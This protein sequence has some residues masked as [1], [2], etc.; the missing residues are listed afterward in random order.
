[1][2]DIEALCRS[3]LA[4]LAGAT[5]KDPAIRAAIEEACEGTRGA[6]AGGVGAIKGT[7]TPASQRYLAPSLAAGAAGPAAALAAAIGR[8][9]GS[10]HWYYGYKPVEGQPDLPNR[11]A[12]CEFVG[13]TSPVHSDTMRLGLTLI[14]PGTHYPVHAHPAVE[15]YYVIAG[16]ARWITPTTDALQPPGAYILHR[17]SEPHAMETQA[18]P[19]LSLYAWSGEILASSVYTRL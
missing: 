14:G 19:L 16:T 15:L 3:A 11:I 17:A 6:L 5:A 12:F 7:A 13:P 8:A 18:E 4:L 9:S 2:T 1:M 10:L